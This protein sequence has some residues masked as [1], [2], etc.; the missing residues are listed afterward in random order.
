[1]RK[2]QTACALVALLALTGL[3]VLA[4]NAAEAPSTS[5]YIDANEKMHEGMSIDFTGNA[6]IDFVRGMIPHHEGAI[7]MAKVVLH[8][9]KDPELQKLANGIIAAQTA[10]IA[11][12]KQWLES[13]PEPVVAKAAP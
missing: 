5:A 11:Q 7:D 13:H 10:E 8:Y 12:M 1:M 2:I 4:G 3:P 9:G 6:D